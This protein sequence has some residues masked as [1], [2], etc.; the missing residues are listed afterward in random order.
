MELREK[1]KLEAIERM[2]ILKLMKNVIRDFEK[3]DIL[4]YSKRQNAFFDG[5]LYWISNEPKFVEIIKSF[6]EKYGFLVY[7]AQLSHTGFGDCLTLLYV[8]NDER[9]WSTEKESLKNG[10]SCCYVYNLDEDLYNEFGYC[11]IEPKNGGVT[12]TC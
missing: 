2:R 10:I 7:H 11:G 5:V 1:Q 6:E 4:Y 3:K 8:S 12:R 9:E